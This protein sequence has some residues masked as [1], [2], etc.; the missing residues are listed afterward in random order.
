VHFHI[1]N[2]AAQSDASLLLHAH[3]PPYCPH[4]GIIPLSINTHPW[5]HN[6]KEKLMPADIAY[7]SAFTHWHVV[8]ESRDGLPA[9]RWERL[10]RTMRV[11]RTK[12][13]T[14]LPTFERYHG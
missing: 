6:K 4:L 14:K 1:G 13:E 10:L 7:D 9:G 3:V 2:L 12:K 11:L 5:V 8:A